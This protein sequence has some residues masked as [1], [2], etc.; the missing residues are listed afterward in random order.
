[1]NES[2]QSEN[3]PDYEIGETTCEFD[4]ST[5]E[6]EMDDDEAVDT[7]GFLCEQCKDDCDDKCNA[8]REIDCDDGSR[9]SDDDSDDRVSS[10]SDEFE[11]KKQENF[12]DNENEEDCD[13]KVNNGS[14][15]VGN[16]DAVEEILPSVTPYV[17]VKVFKKLAGQKVEIADPVC[18]KG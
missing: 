7:K 16:S 12:D 10:E 18:Q 15:F 3:D 1:M 14:H 9:D 13:K 4:D 5:G 2:Y 6:S 8:T 17:N 11:K